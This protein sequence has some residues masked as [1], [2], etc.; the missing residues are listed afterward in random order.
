MA[1]LEEPAKAGIIFLKGVQ[2]V[3]IKRNNF[4]YALR[5]KF[6]DIGLGQLGKKPHL[7]QSPHVVAVAGLLASEDADGEIR[8]HQHFPHASGHALSYFIIGAD[9]AREEEVFLVGVGFQS[10]AAGPVA[11]LGLRKLVG[12]AAHGNGLEVVAHARRNFSFANQFGARFLKDVRQ[13]ILEFGKD[14]LVLAVVAGDTG[15]HN[16]GKA[17]GGFNFAI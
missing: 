12:I 16:L 11:P 7:A 6:F 2:R 15:K 10:R 5:L 9:R 1:H 14:A 4:F 8:V 13:E 3:R 17:R